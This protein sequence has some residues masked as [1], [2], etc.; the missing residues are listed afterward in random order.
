MVI[1]DMPRVSKAQ[2]SPDGSILID[3]RTTFSG[4]M[5]E[6]HL[7]AK[8]TWKTA[9]QGKTLVFDFTNVM[10]GQEMK[11]IFYFVK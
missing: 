1:F 9:D 7:V 8:E 5:G 2:K 4:E 10:S 3:S 6:D 11:G